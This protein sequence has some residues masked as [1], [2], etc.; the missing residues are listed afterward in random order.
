MPF[1]ARSALAGAILL[2]PTFATSRSPE[3]QNTQIVALQPHPSQP[4]WAKICPTG[5]AERSCYV[6]RDF[7]DTDGSAIM[8]IGI[9]ALSGNEDRAIGRVLLPLGLSL[10]SGIRLAV[11]D[12]API[13]GK[14]SSCIQTGC[15]V[16]FSIAPEFAR[17]MRKGDAIRIAALNQYL[18][19]IGFL[20][21]LS[22]LSAA[23]DGPPLTDAA[24][25]HRQANLRKALQEKAA[26]P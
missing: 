11:D 18:N 23:I 21:P 26:Q 5:G 14:F 24:L 1:F 7:V 17:A 20:A 25:A 2:L 13:A 3:V 6:T 22:G 19:E 8:A 15:F 4:E 10:P 16:E 9:Y 12:G